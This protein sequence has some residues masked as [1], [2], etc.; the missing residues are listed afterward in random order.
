VLVPITH[1][2]NAVGFNVQHQLL[3]T[4]NSLDSILDDGN[5]RDYPHHL[6]HTRFVNRTIAVSSDVPP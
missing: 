1:L 5:Q 3:Q 4:R 6:L 2:N